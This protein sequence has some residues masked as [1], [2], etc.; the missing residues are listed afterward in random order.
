VLAVSYD[1]ILVTLP[2]LFLWKFQAD[3]LTKM[4][5]S[6]LL[7]LVEA[8]GAAVGAVVGARGVVVQLGT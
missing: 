5:I 8:I 4:G 2:I 7:S 1:L 3:A 6:C